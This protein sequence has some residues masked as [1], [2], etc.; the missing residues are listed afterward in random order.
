MNVK[1]T[2]LS[3]NFFFSWVDVGGNVYYNL[4]SVQ[5]A[6]EKYYQ[7]NNTLYL[8]R[9]LVPFVRSCLHCIHNVAMPISPYFIWSHT[10]T[11]ISI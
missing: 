4:V 9:K 11:N 5:V 6:S 2:T 8:P 3:S 1:D 10:V 7:N